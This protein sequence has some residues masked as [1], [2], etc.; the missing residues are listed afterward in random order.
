[1]HVVLNIY[2]GACGDA[3]SG[4]GVLT[5]TIYMYT[6]YNNDGNG[7]DSD[8]ELIVIEALRDD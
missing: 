1:M 3:L 6:L 2:R 5:R 7:N 8:S 4:Q